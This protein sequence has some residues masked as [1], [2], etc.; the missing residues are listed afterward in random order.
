M[1]AS[2]VRPLAAVIRLVAKTTERLPWDTSMQMLNPSCRPVRVSKI[3]HGP[4]CA[5]DPQ[6]NRQPWPQTQA[7]CQADEDSSHSR[8]KTSLRHEQEARV[9]HERWRWSPL[10][11][12]GGSHAF[13][14]R[15]Q[16]VGA[17]AWKLKSAP[18]TRESSGISSSE[19]P[20][21]TAGSRAGT[22]RAQACEN[23]F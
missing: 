6:K 17:L 20:V 11:S 18:C 1:H 21:S 19:P 13:P 5:S 16:S 7:V 8:G 10:Q 3:W 12:D 2:L 14:I 23:E 4:V 9:H 15:M 22:F